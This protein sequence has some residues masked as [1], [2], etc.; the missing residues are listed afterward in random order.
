[1][2]E[3]FAQVHERHRTQPGGGELECQR[4]AVE[5]PADGRDECHLGLVEHKGSVLH[6]RPLGEQ[7]H[8]VR[9]LDIRQAFRIARR[10]RERRDPVDALPVDAERLS[11]RGEDPHPWAAPAGQVGELGGGVDD[12]LAVVEDEEHVLLAEGIEQGVEQRAATLVLNAENCSDGGGHLLGMSDG[13]QLD[14]PD[15]LGVTTEQLGSGLQRKACLA[16]TAGAGER[17]EPGRLDEGL[18][19]GQL[20]LAPDEQARQGRQVVRELRVVERSQR[21][22]ARRPNAAVELEHLLGTSEVLQAVAPEVPERHA[23]P[24]GVR[25]QIPQ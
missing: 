24:Q 13:R 17:D 16:R 3:P 18:H 14:E 22:E 5:A 12:V 15:S 11:R 4:D 23:L 7:A 8:G 20:P 2:V 19:V 1:M 21:R 6:P 25:Q 10:Q 9:G